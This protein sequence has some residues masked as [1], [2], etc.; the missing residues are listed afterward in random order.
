V[1]VHHLDCCRMHPP[2]QRLVSG[3]GSL[4]ERGTMVAHVLAIETREGL[5]LVDSGIGI[6][7]VRE[8]VKRLGKGFLA[9]SQP[10]LDEAHTAIR[11]LAALGYKASDVRH[12]VLTH[13]DLDHAGGLS[14]FPEAT[15]HVL[16]G[17]HAAAMAR[18]TRNEA[19]RYRPMQWAHGPK[20]QRHA[21]AGG[22]RFFGFERVRAIVEPE[23]L[24]LPAGGHTRGHAV[25]AVAEGDRW[26]VH[27]G[28]AYFHHD[29]VADPPSCPPGLALFQRLMSVDNA[30]R[31]A[32][33]TRLRE[34][35]RE[36]GG[37]VRVFCA[38]DEEEFSA[39]GQSP[40]PEA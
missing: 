31:I 8:P 33:Q 24:L 10:E 39:F 23:V 20:W 25:V 2:A 15:V 5:V 29:E 28:D 12:I 35:R 26:L 3:R 37:R 38:H 7:D 11:Q 13:L 17:E 32:N 34:L 9:A 1:K 22:E 6:H 21:V 27:A 19:E 14:D 36:A 40:S 30:A 18:T 16:E 4:F